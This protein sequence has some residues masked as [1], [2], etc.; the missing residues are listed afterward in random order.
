VGSS[1]ITSTTISAGSSTAT[2]R[3]GAAVAVLHHGC[4]TSGREPRLKFGGDRLVDGGEQRP[5]HVGGHS[6]GRVP[7]P[8]LDRLDVRPSL[9][10]ETRG[11]VAQPMERE[12]VQ[13]RAPDGWVE[14][15]RAERGAPKRPALGSNEHQR[16]RGGTP[17]VREMLGQYGDH[18]RGD[19]QSPT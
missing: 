2:L 13:T 10:H 18:E 1:P 3:I 12:P 16:V 19:A 17:P 5:V 8:L 9:D 11:G 6:D 4:T 7:E 14:H 15:S